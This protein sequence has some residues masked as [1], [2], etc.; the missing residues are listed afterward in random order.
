MT[1][2][3][4]AP[5]AAEAAPGTVAPPSGGLAVTIGSADHKVV[6]RL[7]IGF[8]LTFL[9]V[10]VVA[11]L[12]VGVERI[13]T[14]TEE[15]LGADTV[16]QVFALY[17]T[18]GL[19]L[20]LWPLVV[21][22]ALVVVPLQ[23]GAR[24]VAFPRAA[25]ASFWG[26][27]VGSG[28]VIGSIAANGGP[29]GGES[30]MVDLYVLGLVIV[31]VSLLLAA[32]SLA[33]T[34]TTLRDEAMA[35]RNVP[36]FS[37]A[38]LSAS[39][40]WLL[41]FPILIANLAIFYVDHRHGG[42]LQFGTNEDLYPQI[43]WVFSPP[44][45]F[46]VVVPLLGVV[47]EI[48]PTFTKSRVKSH[49]GAMVA[50]GLAAILSF[51]AAVQ[52]FF[53]PGANDDAFYVLVGVAGVLPYLMLFGLWALVLKPGKGKER[54]SIDSPILFALLGFALLFGGAVAAAVR[55]IDVLDL[56]GTSWDTAVLS[57]VLFGGAT[58]AFG[59][60]AYW[61][62][63][64]WGGRLGEAAG[65]TSA[66]LLFLGTAL[67]ALPDLWS[68][69]LDQ[70]EVLEPGTQVRDGVEALNGA[71]AAGLALV[72]LGALVF[73]LGLL[74]ALRK[75]KDEAAADPWEGG[76]LEWATASPPARSNFTD[77]LPAIESDRP[78]DDARTAGEES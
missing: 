72:A 55:G 18:A 13:G 39:V 9:L 67:F 76:T 65:R 69:A 8:S 38:T 66:L 19:F 25:A 24:E 40:V 34:V 61:A 11:G 78:L 12:L 14:D 41:S 74:A 35:F 70:P 26:W 47:G 7:Y 10:A 48:L 31:V 29:G 22:I 71:S 20:F 58:V 62:P 53:V 37:F 59:G 6:G 5:T 64:L 2:T 56:I 4:T 44:Q 43:A 33:T 15:V 54:P 75:G 63:K 57:L 49:D 27:L 73:V 17:R 52:P 45:I 50:V 30:D 42:R 3:D 23:V 51:G 77:E 60:V 21:G 1:A 16:F 28:L 68:G 32:I 36:L 46:A